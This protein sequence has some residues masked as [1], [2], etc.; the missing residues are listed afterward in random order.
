MKFKN[1]EQQRNVVECITDLLYGLRK[2]SDKST[3]EAID[4]TLKI[5]RDTEF[6]DEVRE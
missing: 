5:L 3:Q 4:I 1:R 2:F 6:E